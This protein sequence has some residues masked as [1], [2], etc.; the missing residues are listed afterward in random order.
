[1]I[2]NMSAIP[3]PSSHRRVPPLENGDRLTREEFERRYNAMRNLKKAELLDGMVYMPP[4]AVSFGFH[5]LPHADL[6]A[7][8]GVYRA[9]TPGVLAG[10][11]SSLRI[12]TENEPQPDAFLMIT[13][14]CGGQAK[15]DEEK[16]VVGT[17]ELV[18]EIAASSVSYDLHV[19]LNI[20]RQS[21]VRE[22]LVWRTY[23]GE[24]DYFVLVDGKYER[25]A[26]EEGVLKSKIFPGLWLRAELMMQGDLAGVLTTLQ[27]G[28]AG[29][30]HARFVT[31]LQEQKRR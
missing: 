31:R 22:Y 19:K 27:E 4:P 23:D 8:L 20:Y 1:M 26:P 10:D 30:E 3:V 15:L 9:A 5:G 17:P 11:N 24:M 7:W 29:V 13:P 25:L 18:A 14:E 16:Y 28:M 2:R 6:L 21:G 12:D